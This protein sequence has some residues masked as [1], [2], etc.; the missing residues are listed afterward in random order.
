MP[1]KKIS[2][3][4]SFDQLLDNEK[5]L[6]TQSGTNKTSTVPVL[7]TKL[8][9]DVG[10]ATSAYASR[11]TANLA[12]AKTSN[13]TS[14]ALT[15]QDLTGAYTN[16]HVSPNATTAM[17]VYDTSKDSDGGAWTEKCQHTSWYNESL[18]GKW[19][20]AQTS[21]FYA[22]NVNAAIVGSNLVTNSSFSSNTTGWS[23]STAIL[24]SVGGRL[25]VEDNPASPHTPYAVSTVSCTI[26]KSYVFS[27]QYFG[28]T[29]T[30]MLLVAT[31]DGGSN[32]QGLSGLAGEGTATFYFTATASTMYI[33]T[34]CTT[35]VGL[36][37]G[38]FVEFD[39]ISVYEV[40][41]TTNAGDYFQLP[42][43][44]NFYS[45]NRNV[46][47][48]SESTTGWIPMGTYATYTNSA[49]TLP[50]GVSTM[51]LYS[52]QVEGNAL[53]YVAA[54]SNRLYQEFSGSIMALGN[55]TYTISAYV[56]AFSQDTDVG[57]AVLNNGSDN[58]KSSYATTAT[59]SWTRISVT[60]TTDG[61]NT[62]IRF[63]FSS[64]YKVLI[65]GI[66]IEYGS[67][68]GT[69]QY[70]AGDGGSSLTYRGNK[71]EFPKLSAI[72][73]EATNV[74][75]YDLTES[76]RP[77]WMRF[78]N[79]GAMNIGTISSLANSIVA[80][81][82]RL[83]IC[84]STGFFDVDFFKDTLTRCIQN[85][86]SQQKYIS[87]RASNTL[88]VTTSSY[89]IPGSSR[90]N[91]VAATYLPTSPID[92]ISGLRSIFIIIGSHGGAS[93][94]I[95]K[96]DGMT[97]ISGSANY[98]VRLSVEGSRIWYAGNAWNNTTE[99]TYV[100]V[101]N[102]I[103]KLTSAVVA[104]YS[105]NNTRIPYTPYS[106]ADIVVANRLIKNT[107]GVY[108]VKENPSSSGSKTIFSRLTNTYNTGHQ[109]G[110]I[111]RTYLSDVDIRNISGTDLIQNGT[112]D[113]DTTGWTSVYSSILTSTNG[114]LRITR[115]GV[116]YPGAVS[117]GMTTSIG[118][119]YYVKFQ[120][121]TPGG[122]AVFYISNQGNGT[123]GLTEIARPN[124]NNTTYEYSFTATS[125]TT[126]IVF[127][128]SSNASYV[129][130]D[131]IEV[132]DFHT[133]RSYKAKKAF[134]S[135]TLTKSPV[136][137]NAQLVGYSG[138]S[139]TNYLREPYSA[140]LD[141]G[142]GEWGS[143]CWV[144]I[145]SSIN[146]TNYTLIPNLINT[147]DSG[148]DGWGTGGEGITLTNIDGRLLV[149]AASGSINPR[150][151]KNLS[152]KV[153]T[154]YKITV[155]LQSGT[156]NA[157]VLIG[158]SGGSAEYGSFIT[159]STLQ[160]KVFYFTPTQTTIQ[161]QMGWFVGT[162]YIDNF[163]VEELQN[164]CV[165]DRSFGS[166]SSLKLEQSPNYKLNVIV[167][168]GTTTRT[169][170][171]TNAYNTGTWNKVDVTY[172]TN[173][174][175]SLY[176]NGQAAATAVT[177]SAL[178]SLT[179]TSAV[180]TIGNNYSANAP[181]PGSLALLKLSATVPTIDQLQWMYEQEKMMFQPGAQVCLP[182]S[183]AVNDLS[184]DSKTDT[185]YVAQSS[186]LSEFKG[187][188]RTAYR[189][190]ATS[191]YSKIAADSGV[192]LIARASGTVELEIAPIQLKKEFSSSVIDSTINNQ[193]ISIF[194]FDSI[195]S[196]TDFVLPIGYT[197]QA[198]Y[199][200]GTLQ[201]EGASKNYT[202]LF[203]GFRETI[204]FGTAPATNSWVKIK[205]VRS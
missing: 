118:K 81:N 202:R 85:S 84:G 99:T 66:Q 48:Y 9:S 63:A 92:P 112:F 100:S 78:V 83:F 192:K 184:Y 117:S 82:S 4:D 105:Y 151:N 58:I 15:T 165:F 74:T 18:S 139:T 90:T 149:N 120:F 86:T 203:D 25:R 45:L 65:A 195:A 97:V 126:Y 75:I 114:R 110:D 157:N 98:L 178:A 38:E 177:G 73:A 113:T 196:Q 198:V 5:L 169:I 161:F 137:T 146:Y 172:T 61:A 80:L 71:R 155:D 12:A 76:G 22:R 19:L 49:I 101:V 179:N 180:L 69:Y 55:T 60:G 35:G 27:G 138:F 128:I 187:L 122:D 144:N 130:F 36:A 52:P 170:T 142:T 133:D 204:R 191:T 54:N 30:T 93:P 143:S 51:A 72:V 88:A 20:G 6:I 166:G 11:V 96:E 44:G 108:T 121:Y 153:G 77:M 181:F 183:G 201:I 104:D 70:K 79:T 189:K 134:I 162:A 46:I 200:A 141:F 186:H 103:R 147:F 171:S 24:S 175:L 31:N 39:N 116:A 13:A 197:A 111:R 129:E 156:G 1:N 109:I 167:Y 193:N 95:V 199:L 68:V 173:G 123:S 145:P 132:K 131:D 124:T 102:D 125:T 67:S 43:N 23:S 41:Q 28:G 2:Q 91:V 148:F 16:L 136:A 164:A 40:T 159:T 87:T 3:L 160:T 64:K 150:T 152:V 94:A 89:K 47:P 26:G 188:V 158:N 14:A 29:K 190:P 53:S 163:I 107:N 119:T 17:F 10:T 21:E 34:G 115:N 174:T 57:L 194:E 62:G 140:D 56:R 168:D 154:T 7:G 33:I 176:V 50:S 8:N 185:W 182:S 205:A 59:S 135:G 37:I 32:S 127:W 42:S 106:L